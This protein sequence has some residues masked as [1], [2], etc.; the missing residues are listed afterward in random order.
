MKKYLIALCA[1]TILAFATTAQ[2]KDSGAA[3]RNERAQINNGKSQYG[4]HH[5]HRNDM[6]NINLTDAQRQKI[7]DINTDFRNQ[8]KDLENNE[9]I[10]LKDYRAKRVI[11]E[12]ARKSKFRDILTSD[13]KDKLAQAKKERSE[14]MK[15]MAQKRLEKMKTDLNL[16]ADQVA[17]IRDL[18][19]S[20]M[21]QAKAIRENS[22][23][24]ED[25]KKEQLTDLVQSRKES[26][27]NVLT[28]EQLK[29]KGEMKSSRIN[30]VKSKRANKDS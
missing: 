22:S 26:I 13:Q 19:D 25:Q 8:L 6:M 17:K 1:F 2:T 4:M 28:P 29:K 27:N 3:G 10:S 21:E 12:Q 7:K 14:K 20:S 18:R 23:L 24:T 5:R 15:R 11:L 16:S 30:D 9:G